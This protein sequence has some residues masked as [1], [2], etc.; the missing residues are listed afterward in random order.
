MGPGTLVETR[1]QDEEVILLQPFLIEADEGRGYFSTNSLIAT[2][3]RQEIFRTPI[4]ISALTDE[5][6]SD[7]AALDLTDAVGYLGG[8]RAVADGFQP[9]AGFQIRGFKSLW[10][11]RN[12]IRQYAIVGNEN[13]DRVE[14][15]K[16]PSSIFFG[17]V[18]PG[19][20]VN[21]VTKRAS[22]DPLQR[23]TLEY[24]THE[25]QKA[26][27]EAQG[28]LGAS[29]D[30]AYRLVLSALDRQDWR[31]F[32]YEERQF[33]FLGVRW[34]PHRQFSLFAEVE[35][36]W[37]KY[38]DAHELIGGNRN[39]FTDYRNPPSDLVAYFNN[40]TADQV[41]ALWRSNFAAY[42]LSYQAVRQQSPGTRRSHL[43]PEATPR[44]YEFNPHGPD[45]RGDFESTI[46]SA[47]VNWTITP[48]LS[49]RA[50]LVRNENLRVAVGNYSTLMTV[51]DGGIDPLPSV[52]GN[53]NDSTSLTVE[54][55]VEYEAFWAKHRFLFGASLYDD[56]FRSLNAPPASPSPDWAGRW[57]PALDGYV[58][59]LEFFDFSKGILPSG[60]G[61]DN[62]TDALTATYVGSWWRE[63]LTVMAGL[64]EET[65]RK[66][67]FTQGSRDD[68]YGETTFG[69]TTP[70]I[71]AIAEFLPGWS[72]FSSYSKAYLPGAGGLIQG[73]GAT[74]E[75][76][77]QTVP[78][79]EGSGFDLGLKTRTESRQ[80][81]GTISLFEVQFTNDVRQKDE[82]RTD[83]DARNLDND[84]AND[85]TWFTVSGETRS[86]G[87][88]AEFVYAPIPHW[89]IQCSYAW[90][91]EAKVI[92]NPLI[93]E[94]AG[95][96]LADTP[97]NEASLWT[98]YTLTQAGWLEGFSVGLG[99]RY[100]SDFLAATKPSGNTTRNEE[101]W[102]V[103]TLFS[104][105]G[106]MAG[107]DVRLN[108]N[109]R[110]LFD[111]RYILSGSRPGEARSVRLSAT[112]TF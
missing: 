29:R 1:G 43:L 25:Y 5:F 4:S 9:N 22:S 17:Q 53:Q 83:G 95:A 52:I 64:R 59:L 107:R 94:Q 44:G 101:S 34:N 100:R 105:R 112:V 77:R 81:T 87:L 33:A 85:V 30:L 61:E 80:L 73:S 18:A 41:K 2:G 37:S 82:A 19:G 11:S 70:M 39:W 35:R 63:K 92:A 42:D 71:G 74:D 31:D 68:T 55:F 106:Q 51:A 3:F 86:R 104:W 98:K 88:E 90:L 89:Q 58:S 84:P 60:R 109:I 93:P 6:L 67:V 38:N 79:K 110:N 56:Q 78:N 12:G 97:E 72:V 65:Y 14:V 54:F 69:G 27:L 96:R 16:G 50:V 26:T 13:I 57:I 24:G 8:V 49:T 28:P 23:I 20:V 47:E 21:Y 36:I 7:A 99:L 102:L 10:I 48:W 62:T 66:G 76:L 111:E 103:D 46:Y 75:E 108:L 45:G 32:E 91:W 40:L 15:I